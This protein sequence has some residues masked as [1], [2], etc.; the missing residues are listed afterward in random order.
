MKISATLDAIPKAPI[1]VTD[2][3]TV[4]DYAK[5]QGVENPADNLYRI[6]R[7]INYRYVT[8][9]NSSCRGVLVGISNSLDPLDTTYPMKQFYIQPLE[10]KHLGINEMGSPFDQFLHILHP[11]KKT[12]VGES[13]IFARDGNCFTLRDGE[14]TW[15][16]QKMSRTGRV[17]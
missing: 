14:D 13:A 3:N 5:L 4:M 9:E 11:E 8:V 16:V 2:M 12:P 15:W 10:T 17:W 7:S 6:P 1:F